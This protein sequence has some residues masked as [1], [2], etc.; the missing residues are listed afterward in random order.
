M[1]EKINNNIQNV[2]E[3]IFVI[4]IVYLDGRLSYKSSNYLLTKEL[5][6]LKAKGFSTS[7]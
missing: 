3:S 7:S 5:L 1:A 6:D 2:K 4:L